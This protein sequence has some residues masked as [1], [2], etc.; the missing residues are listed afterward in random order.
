MLPLLSRPLLLRLSTPLLLVVAAAA[1]SSTSVPASLSLLFVPLQPF[2]A[3][4]AEMLSTIQY[5]EDWTWLLLV[6]MLEV[7]WMVQ[8]SK[9]YGGGVMLTLPHVAVPE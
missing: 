1:I 8:F 7:L 3:A 4:P 5:C 6:P 9:K 2:V